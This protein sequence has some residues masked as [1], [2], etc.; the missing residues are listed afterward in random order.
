MKWHRRGQIYDFDTSAFCT[1][2]VGFAQSP[3]VLD[4]GDCVRIYFSTRQQSA[5]GKF[6][7]IIQYIEMDPGFR[8]VLRRSNHPVVP[9]GELGSFDEHGIFP[10]SVFRHGNAVWGYL[11]GNGLLSAVAGGHI[12]AHTAKQLVAQP[13]IKDA[14]A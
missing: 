7:S 5:E 4:C 6:V 9:L 8:R 10:F 13:L 3:Q 14:G 2:Y 12:A 1:D 11:S